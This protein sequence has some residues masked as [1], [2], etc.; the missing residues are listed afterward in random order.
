MHIAYQTQASNQVLSSATLT[1]GLTIWLTGLSGAGKTTIGKELVRQ[2][3]AAGEK[4]EFL[5]GDSLRQTIC[6]GLGFSYEDRCE[7]IRRIGFLAELLTRHGITVVVA[8]ISPYQSMRD[9]VRQRVEHFLEVYV[10]APLAVCEQRDVKGLYK[11][12]RAGE[13][14]QFTGVSDPYEPPLSPEVTCF[15]DRET[16]DESVAKILAHFQAMHLRQISNRKQTLVRS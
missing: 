6:R 11:R 8:V 2:L 7:N 14:Q 12:T 5:D 16:I 3:Q 1:R 4:V 10:N 15:T 13:I 9:E